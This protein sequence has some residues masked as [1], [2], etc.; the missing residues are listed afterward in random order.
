MKTPAPEKQLE[1]LSRGTVD[2]TVEEEFLGKLKRSRESGKP[3]RVKLGVDPT[4]PD[5]HLGHTVVLR[6]L[7]QFQDLG[8]KAVLIIGDYTAL[9]GDPS[10]QNKTRPSVSEEE[11][12]HNAQTYFEQVS[13]V[14]DVEAAEIVYNGDWFKG[15]AFA[16]VL[17]LASKVTVARIMERDDF[18]KRWGAHQPISLHE[19]LYPVMQGYDSIMV[20]ADVEV[21]GTD[22]TFNLLMGRQLQRDSGQ[23]AQVTITMPLLVGLDGTEKM[24]KSKGNYIGVT[25]AA[26]EMY[27]K[28][29]SIPDALMGNYFELLTE[30]P[31]VEYREAIESG[32]PRETKALLASTIVGGFRGEKAAAE[33]AAE[34]DRVFREGKLPDDVPEIVIDAAE[35]EDG[36]VWIVRLVTVAGFASSN[37]EARRL[38][39][40]GAVTLDGERVS[41]CDQ[42]VDIKDGRILKVGK[43]RF[44]RITLQ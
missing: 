26:A 38:V 44:G 20:R 36:R 19:L 37:G 14:L 24:S 43:R 23:E 27:G 5:I 35:M 2:I 15:L 11:V 29:M 8:H 1:L 34:F 18:A 32:H 17:K 42:H 25:E 28:L 30:V 3:L 9:V 22:Q 4:S 31:E 12:R 13:A 21:G 39:S 16:E 33:A 41:D 40:Q 7:R 10:D 6:K